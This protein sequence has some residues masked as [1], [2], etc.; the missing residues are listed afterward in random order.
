MGLRSNRRQGQARFGALALILMV[1]AGC[2][3]AGPTQPDNPGPLATSAPIVVPQESGADSTIGPASTVAAVT[4]DQITATYQYRDELITPLAHLYGTFLA[5]F[6]VITI[7][8]DNTSPVRVVA[9][10]EIPNYT[11]QAKD[12][13]DIAAGATEKI[14][15]NPR[16]TTA[17]ID[18]LNSSHQADVH[19][20]VSYLDNGQSRIVLDQTST[21]LVTSRR[22]FPWAIEGFKEHDEHELIAAMVTPSDPSVEALIRKAVDYTAKRYMGASLNATDALDQLA[23]IWQAEDKV[24]NL[25]Y[26]STTE[27]F[28]AQSQRIRLPGEVLPEASGNCIELTLLYAAVS[29]AIGL[30]GYIILIPGHAYFV[31]DLDGKGTNFEAIETTMI[32]AASFAD[33][34]TAGEGEFQTAAEHIKAGDTS[35]DIVDVAAARAKGITPIEWH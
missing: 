34:V 22:D 4:V 19:V 30:K 26:V 17:A 8:N 24:Y 18:G 6:V 5:P 29:E 35:Y 11:S 9:M 16:L 10:S 33:A 13:I 3:S 14:N 1:V 2:S 31:V 12:T 28:A 20:T 32:G 7:K 27:T 23:A 21:T 15:Q 25:V